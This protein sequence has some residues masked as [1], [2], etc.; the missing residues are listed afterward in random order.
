M[1]ILDIKVTNKND[2]T[3]K[4]QVSDDTE[5]FLSTE[6]I[7]EK[8]EKMTEK[9]TIEV[10]IVGGEP[11]LCD[12]ILD[13]IKA[14]KAAPGV[15]AVELVTNGALLKGRTKELKDAGLDR[16]NINLDTLKYMKFNEISNGGSLDDIVVGIN[17]AID[18]DFRP[19]LITTRIMK[20]FNQD[21]ILDFLQLTFQH[22]YE[23]V[24]TEPTKKEADACGFEVMTIEEIKGVMPGLRPIKK[25]EEQEAPITEQKYKYAGAR[26]KVSFSRQYV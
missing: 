4:Y 16:I 19:V 18:S 1:Q 8:V 21:E 25:A 23:I 20:G 2:F 14:I 7:M 26:G 6:E 17:E 15:S 22:D 3:F 10:R 13:I 9:E 11:L 12:N 5:K 24:F